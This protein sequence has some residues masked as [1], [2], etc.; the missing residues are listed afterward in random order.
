MTSG[1]TSNISDGKYRDRKKAI[2]NAERGYELAPKKEYACIDTLGQRMPKAATR[3]PRNGRRR[4][5][6][7]LTTR[8]TETEASLPLR[9]LQA[10]KQSPRAEEEK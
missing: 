2:A 4:P 5:S 9:T 7:W 6:K 1:V 10:R 3:E 8:K